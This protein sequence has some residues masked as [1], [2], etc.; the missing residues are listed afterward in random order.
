MKKSDFQP[1]I[2]Y[3]ED[4]EN[5]QVEISRFLTRYTDKLY[6]AENGKEGL[7]IY[8]K[9]RP[10]IV[11]S[12]IKMPVMNGIEMAKHIKEID[13]RQHIVF[14]TAHSESFYM[15][16]T[17]EMNIDGYVLKPIDYNKL[18][19]KLDS[20]KEQLM[21]AKEL[22]QYQ[23]NLEQRVKE[24]IEK[25]KEQE[26]MLF[27]QSN[28]AQMGDMINM[29]A[30]QWRQPLNIISSCSS[31][32]LLAS[33]LGKL[34]SNK[35]E[36]N[37]DTINKTT[38]SMSEIIND[39]MN[40]NKKSDTENISLHHSV[41][42][43][44]KIILP[45][46]KEKGINIENNIDKNLKV[47]HNPRYIKHILLNLIVNARDA[48]EDSNIDGKTIE[49]YTTNDNNNITLV[50][51]DNAGGIPAEIVNRVFE[52]YFSTKKG[53]KGTGLGLY[54]SKKLMSSVQNGHISVETEGS[55]TLFILKFNINDKESDLN[56]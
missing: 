6:I 25:N 52:P 30:H 4:E 32:I 12:D 22:K 15:M 5:I 50:I 51:K 28:L 42:D 46:C 17:I 19:Y 48:F 13:P 18:E 8:K 14:T 1:I 3:V 33:R 43:V 37:C 10:D 53:N 41:E 26:L 11:I 49:A 44:K 56:S 39:F 35:I 34:N 27:E 16:E 47:Y 7:D 36:K 55:Y 9:Y 31:Y 2:L 23:E 45:Q 20:I 54:M 24:Q 29:I 21:Q 40:F 38:H